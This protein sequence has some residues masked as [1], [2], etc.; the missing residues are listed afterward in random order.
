MDHEKLLTL[1]AQ[2]VADGRVLRL[3]EAILKAGS[4]GQG[5]LFPSERGTSQGSVV[6]P[7]LSNILLTPFDQEMRSKGFQ[8][9]RFA[10]DW[11]ITCRS[12]AEA[13]AAIAAALRILKELGV[14]LHPQKTRVVH[15][16]HGFEF[17]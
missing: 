12:E 10:D 8:L 4:Y 5:R 17:L 14:E 3:I 15:V 9:T 13:H 6:S 7:L 11:V 2:R 1:V 16:Q